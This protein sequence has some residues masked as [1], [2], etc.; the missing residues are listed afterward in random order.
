MDEPAADRP[1]D[2]LAWAAALLRLIP[3]RF[4]G[5]P[6][7]GWYAGLTNGLPVPNLPAPGIFHRF[8]RGR[9]AAYVWVN[10]EGVLVSPWHPELRG[11]R[12][13]RRVG[14]IGEAL[15]LLAAPRPRPWWRPW[16]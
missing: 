12:T 4:P 15:D 8:R 10:G 6:A 7:V 5:H 11:A 3:E 14:S 9:Q 1:D 13:A 2:R 16:H